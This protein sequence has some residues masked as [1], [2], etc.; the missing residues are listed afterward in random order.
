MT[1]RERVEKT[2]WRWRRREVIIRDDYEC[3]NNE[4]DAKGGPRGDAELHVHHRT[5][6]IDGGTDAHANFE[7]LCADCHRQHPT[8]PKRR[9]RARDVLDVFN[10]RDDPGEPL[11]APEVA[12]AF[13]CSR[14]T[15]LDRLTDLADAG[16][17]RSKQVGGR[18]RVYWLP[19][20]ATT[21]SLGTGV[22]Q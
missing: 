17:L 18:S 12:D 2:D 9:F 8:G 20:P 13:S 19:I 11:T 6:V 10:D 21:D 7:T 5:R 16:R 1:T 15:A 3:Q 4:C 22:A 14:R